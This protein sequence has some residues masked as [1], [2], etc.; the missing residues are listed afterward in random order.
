MDIVKYIEESAVPELIQE[1]LLVSDEGDKLNL[2]K[3]LLASQDFIAI[4]AVFDSFVSFQSER[5]WGGKNPFWNLRIELKTKAKFILCT[6]ISSR[7]NPFLEERDKLE[8]L[9]C[10]ACETLGFLAYEEQDA[11]LAFKLL[12]PDSPLHMCAYLVDRIIFNVV[13][14]TELSDAFSEQLV[15]HYVNEISNEYDEDYIHVL[16][17]LGGKKSI[18]KLR[19]LFSSDKSEGLTLRKHIIV[20]SLNSGKMDVIREFLFDA[21]QYCCLYTEASRQKKEESFPIADFDYLDI[22]ERVES[23]SDCLAVW[24]R[25]VST[26]TE[27][28]EKLDLVDKWLTRETIN[29]LYK[30]IYSSEFILTLPSEIAAKILERSLVYEKSDYV[31]LL[32]L[33][34]AAEC[35]ATESSIP[36]LTRIIEEINNFLPSA[37]LMNEEKQIYPVN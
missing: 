24:E 7:N 13:S 32:K 34:N 35:K 27:V 25:L 15:D 31:G 29:L 36:Q 30:I 2:A 20:E 9:L 28:L 10:L 5:R 12:I 6:C 26:D 23:I 3:K 18:K 16:I 11:I 4:G 37:Q 21:Q 33:K 14:Y 1:F 19:E 17:N 8:Y 22:N